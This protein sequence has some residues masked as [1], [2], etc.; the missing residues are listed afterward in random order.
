ACGMIFI[1]CDGQSFN[2]TAYPELAKLYPDGK[3]PDLRGEFVRGWDNGRGVDAGRTLLSSQ[4]D[5]FRSHSHLSSVAVNTDV[6]QN[7]LGTLFN[8]AMAMKSGT[9]TTLYAN[10]TTQ[11]LATGGAET[12]PRNIA[13]NK[14]MRA[15]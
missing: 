12:R 11:I 7:T 3:A 6:N 10:G 4:S 13:F 8:D 14:I 2:K 15:A 9:P 1:S 5:L